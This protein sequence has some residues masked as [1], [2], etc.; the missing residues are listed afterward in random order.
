M[1][2]SD[3]EDNRKRSWAEETKEH[4]C[5]VGPLCSCMEDTY[6]SVLKMVPSLWL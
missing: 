6:E 2:N 3:V 5:A 1:G 4:A